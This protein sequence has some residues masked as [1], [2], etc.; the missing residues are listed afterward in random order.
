MTPTKYVKALVTRTLRCEGE[1]E[2]YAINELFPERL[3][4]SI[5]HSMC[6]YL[7]S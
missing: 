1:Y 6:E 5:C 2:K 7:K 4:A 3:G